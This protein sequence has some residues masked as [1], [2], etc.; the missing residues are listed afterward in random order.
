MLTC[1]DAGHSLVLGRTKGGAQQVRITSA[2]AGGCCPIELHPEPLGCPRPP[3]SPSSIVIAANRDGWRGGFYL[4]STER[5]P[6]KM[7]VAASQLG[8]NKRVRGYKIPQR[9]MC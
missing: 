7:H 6:T 9:L 3:W 8:P 4:V 5:R 1:R 2:T